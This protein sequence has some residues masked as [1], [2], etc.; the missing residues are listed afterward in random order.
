ML[1][2]AIPAVDGLTLGR[3]EG[4]LALATALSTRCREEL[5]VPGLAA[6]AIPSTGVVFP[7]RLM[8]SEAVSAVDGL[9]LGRLERHVALVSAVCACRLEILSRSLSICHI[10]TLA[11]LSESY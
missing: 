7:G 1:L 3:P 11:L 10:D 9:T 2:E 6:V 5:S 4:D 8:F